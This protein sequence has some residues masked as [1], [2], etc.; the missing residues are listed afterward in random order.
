[1]YKM[2]VLESDINPDRRNRVALSRRRCRYVFR[3]FS[4][5]LV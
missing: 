5:R 1:M 2:I 4:V 3:I